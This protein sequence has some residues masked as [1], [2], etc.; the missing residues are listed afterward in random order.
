MEQS[1]GMTMA[2]QIGAPLSN[3]KRYMNVKQCAEYCEISRDMIYRYCKSNPPQMPY[4]S[5]GKRAKR[6]DRLKI[7]AWLEQRTIEAKI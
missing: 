7:D 5:H 2:A 1:N 3:Q 6:F 4:I